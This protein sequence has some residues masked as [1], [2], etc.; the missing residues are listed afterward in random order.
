MKEKIINFKR[1]NDF[2]RNVANNFLFEE[3]YK[4]ALRYYLLDFENS[5]KLGDFQLILADNYL[6]CRKYESAIF[7]Y[8]LS[9]RTKGLEEKIFMDILFCYLSLENEQKAKD[10]FK[11][12]QR[13]DF[14][15]YNSSLKNRIFFIP[16]KEKAFKI[17]SN[18]SL[19]NEQLVL[20]RQLMQKQKYLEASIEF[21]KIGHFENELVRLES[22]L[23]FIFSNQIDKAQNLI[24]IYGTN[25]INDLC[26]QLIIYKYNDDIDNYNNLKRHILQIN[27]L[28]LSSCFRLAMVFAYVREDYLA[29]VFLKKYI[30]TAMEVN[31]NLLG[32]YLIACMNCQRFDVAKNYLI[33]L[34]NTDLFNR[35]AI[36]YYL[37][38]C[39]KKNKV[40]L[41]Y[42]FLH[43]PKKEISK[44]SRIIRDYI[45][46]SESALYKVFLENIDLFYFIVNNYS[47]FNCQLLLLK[48][49]LINSN[50]KELLLFFDYVFLHDSV[51][52]KLRKQ[53]FLNRINLGLK[54]GLFLKDGLPIKIVLPKLE[55]INKVNNKI[56]NSLILAVEYVLKNLNVLFVDFESIFN[57]LS[58]K[59]EK[60]KL[61]EK[62][63]ACVFLNY[64]ITS[65]KEN[66]LSKLCNYFKINKEDVFNFINS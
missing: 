21:E 16:K 23:S 51:N 57:S 29:M 58:K 40:E 47:K 38:V 64:S 54:I 32:Y 39:D 59:F 1:P 35:Y 26:N 37:K 4:N 12:M 66:K 2:Y 24:N 9:L 14:V 44:I 17:I 3:D 27:D 25:C 30:D 15:D 63:M 53:L 48:L 45:S 52:Y 18:Q 61:N 6:L 22:V 31:D 34:K 62:V 5:N 20:P 46:L 36:N 11:R 33:D 19:L 65:S 55:L 10:L 28:S 49:S 60:T 56:I 8:I 43:L 7:Y 50:K 13:E 41:P 42:E